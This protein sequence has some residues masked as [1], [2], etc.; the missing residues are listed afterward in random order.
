MTFE[1]V[2]IK[3]REN[4]QGGWKEHIEKTDPMDAL[5]K[6]E[7]I[8]DAHLDDENSSY[9]SS[10]KLNGGYNSRKPDRC[11]STVVLNWKGKINVTIDTFYRKILDNKI[12]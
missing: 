9:Q 6:F 10:I 8:I 2:E 3:I 7:A 1:S 12:D 11:G 5:V 4:K